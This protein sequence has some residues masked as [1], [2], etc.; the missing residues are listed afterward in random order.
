MTSVKGSRGQCYP[1]SSEGGGGWGASGISSIGKMR[2][3]CGDIR[4]PNS[5][6]RH[7]RAASEVFA[8]CPAA[9]VSKASVRFRAVSNEGGSYRQLLT[10]AVSTS[11]RE[12]ITCGAAVPRECRTSH[13]PA[14]TLLSGELL[15]A[16]KAAALS[17][18]RLSWHCYGVYC[19]RCCCQH[20]RG[21]RGLFEKM[22]ICVDAA[23]IR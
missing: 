16:H 4:H 9:L 20:R 12:R 10:T 19:C 2:G 8:A 14:P 6:K 11:T 21:G 17:P 5:L 7:F 15:S 18:L 1:R 23:V 13:R 3:V 22:A